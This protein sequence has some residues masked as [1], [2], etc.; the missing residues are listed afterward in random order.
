MDNTIIFH[1]D[2]NSAFLSWSAVKRLK[3]DPSSVDLRTI[4]SAVGGDV[5]SRH[6]IITA[7]SIPAKKYDIKTG[8][9]VV[10]AL[11][12]C[13][14][15]VLV[16]ADFET[17]KKY[18]N[19]FLSI[20]RKYSEKVEQA[21]IDEAYMDV[22]G[23]Y[24]IYS[25]FETESLKFPLSLAYHIKN[26]IRDTLGFTVNV[27]VSS[28]KLLAKMASDFEKPDKVHTLFPDEIE[29]KMWPLKIG[30]LFGCGGKTA[31]KLRSYGI[32]TIGDAAHSSEKILKSILGEKAGEYIFSASNGIG[33]TF[34]NPVPED[35]KS[36]S[37]EWTVSHD[38]NA[39]NFESEATSII[40]RLSESVGKR[41]RR[42]NVYGRT[43]VVS[44]KTNEFKRH[45]IQRGLDSSTN[46]TEVIFST[47]MALLKELSFGKNDSSFDL[48]K[49]Q[50][51]ISIEKGHII[52]DNINSIEHF[53]Y[54][55]GKIQGGVHSDGQIVNDMMHTGL[56]YDEKT[57]GNNKHSGILSD[58]HTGY[59]LLGVG[60]TNLDHGEERQ[61]SIFD[62]APDSKDNKKEL[63]RENRLDQMEDEIKKRFGKGAIR[64]GT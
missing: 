56:L 47:A 55:N 62:F 45:S 26:E 16:P 42:D 29:E 6:G 23:T 2:V 24:R 44:V 59:R 18:S 14:G 28:N 46:N 33:S 53:S 27:G 37:N 64:K 7:K 4:P 50:G 20:L 11:K 22:S 10:K 3:E 9:P 30:D 58:G 19:A 40:R 38:I 39:S 13:P 61:L 17:Y 36:Y 43:V 63:E 52:F 35:A 57:K 5:D 15:L 60:V 21:S 8:M 34:V 1:I 54:N 31:E 49:I 32:K 48:S 25:S 41:L 51:E 12:Q